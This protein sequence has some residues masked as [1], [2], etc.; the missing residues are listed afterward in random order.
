MKTGSGNGLSE[1]WGGFISIITIIWAVLP[2]MAAFAPFSAP[3]VHAGDY[4]LSLAAGS[5]KH[6][7]GA[8][9][10]IG[11]LWCP[12]HFSITE[13]SSLSGRLEFDLGLMDSTDTTVDLGLQPVLRFTYGSSGV[14]PYLDLGAGVHFLSRSEI[15][16]REM[17]GAFQFSLIA[18]IGVDINRNIGLGYRFLHISNANIHKNN[19]GRDEHLAIL[20]W[21]F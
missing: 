20:S 19:D 4:S 15:R 2:L 1:G 6:G 10:L 21:R 18:G 13:N 3:P 17:G 14:Q 11:A 16:G 8:V 9:R 12:H 7:S 5:D